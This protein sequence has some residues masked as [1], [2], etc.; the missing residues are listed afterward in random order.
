MNT[1]IPM[2]LFVSAVATGFAP[3]GAAQEARRLKE[4]SASSRSSSRIPVD[5]SLHGLGDVSELT[6]GDAARGGSVSATPPAGSVSPLAFSCAPS[7]RDQANGGCLQASSTPTPGLLFPPPHDGGLNND[8]SGQYSFVGGG[9]VNTTSDTYGTVGGG[10]SNTASGVGATVGGGALSTASGDFTAVAGGFANYA[11][12]RA[13]TIAGGGSNNATQ[14]YTTIGGGRL[15]TASQDYA[16][17]AGGR[18]NTA[19]AI[20]ATVGGGRNNTASYYA[21]V[22]GGRDNTAQG[23]YSFAAGRAARAN[24]IGAFVWGDS[25]IEIATTKSSSALDQFNVYCSGGA[26]FFTMKDASTGVLLAAGAGSWSAVSDR[27]SKENVEPVDERAVLERL[28]SMPLSTRNYK[29]QDDSVRHMGPMAQDFRAAFGLGVSDKLI[30]TIDP[31]GVALAAI[32]GLHALVQKNEMLLAERDA[33]IDEL[34]ERL[35]RLEAR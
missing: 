29:A 20:Y 12:G 1:T 14:Y 26:R 24:H 2:L 23:N 32:Q 30:D 27:D 10:A 25:Q 35:E 21:V 34:R 6:L 31:D 13:A 15:N 28:V 33:E 5:V 19:S 11:S 8:S 7:I 16:T 17:V 22:P 9:Y 4:P 18:D 3:Q